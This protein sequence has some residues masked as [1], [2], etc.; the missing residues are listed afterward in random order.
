MFVLL[1][2]GIL[3]LICI[4]SAFEPSCDLHGNFALT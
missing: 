2:F 1:I 4:N 3:L